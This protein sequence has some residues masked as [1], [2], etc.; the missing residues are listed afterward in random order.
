MP[1]V[2]TWVD[3]EGI[4]LSETSQTEKDKNYM[5]SLTVKSEVVKLID[6][7]RRTVVTR[8]DGEGLGT[9]C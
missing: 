4:M 1:F 7:D 6:S 2:T 5:M 9:C 3:L 8:L